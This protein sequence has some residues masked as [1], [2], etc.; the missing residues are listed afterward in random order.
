MELQTAEFGR[1][2]ALLRTLDDEQWMA[3]TICPD[4]NVHRM[5]MHVLA[6]LDAGA[7]IRENMHQL[8]SGWKR[9]KEAGESLAD[10]ISANQV[11]ERKHLSPAEVLDRLERTLPKGIKG[12]QRTPGLVRKA[13]I[14]ID[15]PVVEKWELGYLI[16]IIYLRDPWMHRI[17]TAAATGAE[18]ELTADHDGRIVAEI[19]SE[20]ARRHGQPFSLE[21]T[22]AAGGSFTAGE[23]G[24]HIEMDAIEFCL[25]LS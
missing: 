12:R 15:A 13:K 25:V 23:G 5:W 20:W 10:A 16:D 7:S 1:A 9:Q 17:D 21:L 24:E 2:I 14:S 11:E 18:L 22:G 4:W 19:V 3:Q 6:E 8:R